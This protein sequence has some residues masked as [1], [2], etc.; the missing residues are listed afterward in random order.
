MGHVLGA[1]RVSFPNCS[2]WHPAAYADALPSYHSPREFPGYY[3]FLN[4]RLQGVGPQPENLA[5]QLLV[6][7]SHPASKIET[8]S[9]NN[10]ENLYES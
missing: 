2:I 5:D 7:H 1:L 8:S 3:Y 6:K 10:F 9:D 4:Q